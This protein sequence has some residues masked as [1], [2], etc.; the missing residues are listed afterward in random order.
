MSTYCKQTHIYKITQLSKF[1]IFNIF[2]NLNI[3]T[4]HAHTHYRGKLTIYFK[5]KNMKRLIFTTSL[6]LST[7]F[8]QLSYSAGSTVGVVVKPAPI[9]LKAAVSDK[10]TI[11]NITIKRNYLNGDELPYFSAMGLRN[12]YSTTKYT[13]D[14]LSSD[15]F[16]NAE[17]D[18]P[19]VLGDM[20]ISIRTKKENFVGWACPAT[21]STS[22][23]HDKLFS[24]WTSAAQLT[25]SDDTFCNYQTTLPADIIRNLLVDDNDV[26]R[27]SLYANFEIGSPQWE[28]RNKLIVGVII[29]YVN[30]DLRQVLT[31]TQD[32]LLSAIPN[33]TPL[34]NDFL[35][36]SAAG[37]RITS[38]NGGGHS[39]RN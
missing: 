8:A 34:V 31:D 13:A 14:Y 3:G 2:N 27:H 25:G 16:I 4:F 15:G 38:G 1:K 24:Y 20:E 7:I 18:N 37:I 22:L 32:E 6:L 17:I 29:T 23:M 11:A 21:F 33:N 35:G 30:A 5:G 19:F 26:F 9:Q 36:D 12:F 28:D 39:I 10:T